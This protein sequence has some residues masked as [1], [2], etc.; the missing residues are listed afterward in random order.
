MRIAL[1]ITG[2]TMGGAETQVVRMADRFVREGHTVLLLF[3]GGQAQVLPEESAVQVLSLG[4]ERS[5]RTLPAALRAARKRL[6]S[7][8]PEVVHSHL[9]HANIFA[10]LLR[11]ACPLPR[12]VCSAHSTW[13]GSFMHTLAYRLTDPLADLFT[14]VSAAAVE[15]SVAKGIAPRRKA[16]CLY[17]GIPLKTFQRNEEA[18]LALRAREG[19]APDAFVYLAVGRLHPAKDYP[20][21]L[22]AFSTVAAFDAAARLLIVG[23]GDQESA[24]RALAMT[25][26]LD[27]RVRFLGLRRDVVEIMSAADCLVSSSAW[28]GFGLVHA[29]A[30]AARLFVVATDCG[31]PREV[32]GETGILVRPGDPASLAR[33]M[34]R[35]R[36]LG[37]AERTAALD[38]AEKRVRERFSLEAAESAW[39]SL[40]SKGNER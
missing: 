30:M 22:R 40:Y 9:F 27:G 17:N 19:L 34:A 37:P 39:L 7:F 36:A 33:A 26:A 5:L 38:A 29:E 14:N 18:G 35:V 24:L 6:R 3:L 4:L 32:M 23:Q 20:T 2:L 21:L 8:R 13:E 11:L 12:L 15:A 31:G 28:E 10:R 1:I 25:L 16:R